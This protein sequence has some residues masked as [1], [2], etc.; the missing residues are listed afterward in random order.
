MGE[1]P[2]IV[3]LLESFEASPFQRGIRLGS[4]NADEIFFTR[5]FALKMGL[6]HNIPRHA[7]SQE[8]RSKASSEAIDAAL[9]LRNLESL[10]PVG[11]ICWKPNAIELPI[12]NTMKEYVRDEND[13]SVFQFPADLSERERF[14]ANYVAESLELEHQSVETPG[15]RRFTVRRF[16]VWKA[17][18][19]ATPSHGTDSTGSAPLVPSFLTRSP[20]WASQSP[21]PTRSSEVSSSPW[22]PVS[23][24]LEGQSL[25]RVPKVEEPIA[26]LNGMHSVVEDSSLEASSTDMTRQ[27]STRVILET[28]ALTERFF[29]HRVQQPSEP[30]RIENGTGEVYSVVD[31]ATG[32][33]AIFKPAAQTS[34]DM[35]RGAAWFEDHDQPTLQRTLS[36]SAPPRTLSSDPSSNARGSSS[37]DRAGAAKKEVAAY[38]LDHF[39]FAGVLPTVEVQD[40]VYTFLKCRLSVEV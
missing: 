40:E 4:L 1:S 38:Y 5:Y 39:G 25:Q 22:R 20:T 24:P 32:E 2:R 13:K 3:K 28:T 21:L 19:L 7:A 36:K 27:I 31:S 29:A 12:L 14:I 11:Y 16:T 8:P 6:L 10:D 33:R 30:T 18:G 17:G 35:R 26:G 9:P 37:I 23:T 34:K 15:G